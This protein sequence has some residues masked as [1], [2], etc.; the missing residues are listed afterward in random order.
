MAESTV[1]V[2]GGAP[3]QRG[4]G[5]DRCSVLISDSGAA[6]PGGEYLVL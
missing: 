4:S 1:I 6:S 2:D 3:K 5:V